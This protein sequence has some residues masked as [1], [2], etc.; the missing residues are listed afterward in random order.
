MQKDFHYSINHRGSTNCWHSRSSAQQC[1]D[2]SS[3]PTQSPLCFIGSTRS[4]SIYDGKLSPESRI[5]A[6]VFLAK[7]RASH[8]RGTLLNKVVQPANVRSDLTLEATPS[9][10]DLA[11]LSVKVTGLYWCQRSNL[12]TAKTVGGVKLNAVICT[13]CSGFN[14]KCDLP[15]VSPTVAIPPQHEVLRS[16]EGN[17]VNPRHLR[18]AAPMDRIQQTRRAVGGSKRHKLRQETACAIWETRNDWTATIAERAK[19]FHM[20]EANVQCSGRSTRKAPT[21]TTKANPSH[22]YCIPPSVFQ[23]HVRDGSVAVPILLAN[24]LSNIELRMERV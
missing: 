21:R 24:S 4:G 10:T 23:G 7:L 15:I 6:G 2:Q 18:L 11:R 1:V 19:M 22:A 9:L 16:S 14:R 3:A 5:G 12:W 17:C 13:E 20:N 8:A